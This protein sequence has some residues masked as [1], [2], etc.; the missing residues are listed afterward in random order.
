VS[1]AIATGSPWKFP[2]DSTYGSG[3]W[4]GKTNGLSVTLFVSVVT[5]LL[6]YSKASLAAP[7]T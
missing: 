3:S 5:T 7:C 6:T 1:I 4:L 2:P